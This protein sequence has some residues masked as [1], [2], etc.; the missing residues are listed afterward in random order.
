MP[1]S[2]SESKQILNLSEIT[3]HSLQ[4]LP[5]KMSTRNTEKLETVSTTSPPKK[6]DFSAYASISPSNYFRAFESMRNKRNLSSSRT[7]ND[8]IS[9]L[10]ESVIISEERKLPKVRQSVPSKNL[11]HGDLES[12]SM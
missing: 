8:S 9:L 7:A 1:L 4:K 10:K 5:P 3:T 2:K 12:K 11:L 6:N